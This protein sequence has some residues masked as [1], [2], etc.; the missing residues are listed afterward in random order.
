MY[1]SSHI[2]ALL[3]ARGFRVWPIKKGT[4]KAARQGFKAVNGPDVSFPPEEFGDS[5]VAIL[6]GPCALGN[7]VCVDLDAGEWPEWLVRTPTLTSKGGRHRWYVD[8]TGRVRQKCPWLPGIDVKAGLGAYS[9]E[10][11]EGR[12]LFDDLAAPIADLPAGEWPLKR[13]PA[14]PKAP[15]PAPGATTSG[16]A[17]DEASLR[18]LLA[19]RGKGDDTNRKAGALGAMLADHGWPEEAAQKYVEGLLGGRHVDSAMTKFRANREQTGPHWHGAQT[20]VGYGLRMLGDSEIELARPG[21]LRRNPS[22]RGMPWLIWGG[23]V[24]TPSPEESAQAFA[25]RAVPSLNTLETRERNKRRDEVLKDH[26]RYVIWPANVDT[27]PY[28]LN[29]PNGIVDLTTG[30]LMPHDPGLFCSRLAG[31]RFDDTQPTDEVERLV[32]EWTDGDE[33]TA[34]Y[35]WLMAGY[36]ATGLAKERHFAIIHGPPCSG[37]LRRVDLV[38][39]ALGEYARTVPVE[40]W[41]RGTRENAVAESMSRVVGTRLIL[42]HEVPVG[43]RFNESLVKA[44]SGGGDTLTAAGKWKTEREF[45][46][47][48]KL[49]ITGNTVPDGADAALRSRARVI[50]FTRQFADDPTFKNKID[51]LRGQCLA[52]MVRAAVDYVRGGERLPA[53][54]ARIAGETAETMTSTFDSW[55]ADHK[56]PGA[57]TSARAAWEAWAREAGGSHPKTETAFGRAMRDRAHEFPKARVRANGSNVAG[58]DNLDVNAD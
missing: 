5:D 13:K 47:N 35:L 17:W 48:G 56:R 9:I 50:P 43:A 54:P 52:R 45:T 27:A 51:G 42:S 3:T 24:W 29:C 2:A 15:A 28:V 31:A 37:K 33:D 30:K 25:H 10:S 7:L 34:E 16:V 38:S 32:L 11:R 40:T 20:L 6:T 49:W 12:L 22:D 57:Q 55:L 44:L 14:T 4:K 58:F 46:P 19:D 41:L 23:T 53:P 39:G 36:A 21:Q 1:S 26:R 8:P 18:E